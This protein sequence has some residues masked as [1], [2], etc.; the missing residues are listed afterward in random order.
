MTDDQIIKNQAKQIEYLTRLC[1]IKDESRQRY[2]DK[3]KALEIELNYLQD[4]LSDNRS[5]GMNENGNE[6]QPLF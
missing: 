2:V 1:E 5:T 6:I 3:I 4:T